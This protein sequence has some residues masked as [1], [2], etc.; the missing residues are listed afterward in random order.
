M[1]VVGA[2]YIGLEAAAV[3]SQLGPAGDCARGDAAGSLARGGAGDRRVLHATSTAR[4]GHRH[5]LGASSRAFEG[6]GHVTGVRCWRE[7]RSRAISRCVG[8]GVLPNLELALGG[9]ARLRQRHRGRRADAA[10]AIRTCS[11]RATSPGGRWSITGAR[12]GWSPSTT[13]SRAARSPPRPFWG[14]PARAGS[15][16][17]LV[18]PVRSQAADSGLMDRGGP[19]DRARRPAMHGLLRCFTSRKAAVIAVDAVNSAPNTW[20]ER[21]WLRRKAAVAPGELADK[22]ISM[23]DIGARALGVV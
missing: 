3:G 1:V 5:R 15:A 22:S 2:G 19:D 7:A 8:V 18:G 17:V 9:R 14:Q 6:V 12:A 10:P 11:R 23:K 16:L 21:S 4:R 20:S 13:P